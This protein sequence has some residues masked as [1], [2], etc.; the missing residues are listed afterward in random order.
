MKKFCLASV[1]SA[2]AV[3]AAE[4]GSVSNTFAVSLSKTCTIVNA[5]WKSVSEQKSVGIIGTPSISRRAVKIIA[6]R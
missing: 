2:K 6:M 1:L 5:V 4:V 3:M